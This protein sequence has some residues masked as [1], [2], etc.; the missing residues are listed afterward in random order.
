[1][2]KKESSETLANDEAIYREQD[3][4]SGFVVADDSEEADR[5]R[6]AYNYMDAVER[7]LTQLA[8]IGDAEDADALL[9]CLSYTAAM[10]KALVHFKPQAAK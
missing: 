4:P 2:A 1:M 6:L 9:W 5:L 3:P 8:S 7:G 10:A